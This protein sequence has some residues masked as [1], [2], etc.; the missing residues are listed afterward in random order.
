MGMGISQD[1]FEFKPRQ[2]AGPRQP[3]GSRHRGRTGQRR[4]GNLFRRAR[5]STPTNPNIHI[6]QNPSRRYA[7][8]YGPYGYQISP[9]A[10]QS[11]LY[12]GFMPTPYNNYAIPPYISPQRQMMMSP[13]QFQPLMM[14]QNIPPYQPG[15]IPQPNPMMMPQQ[16]PPMFPPY[17]P[18][19]YP[20]SV[21]PYMQ[22]SPQMQ[23]YYNNA[24]AF[25]PVSSP[26]MQPRPQT[27][28]ILNNIGVVAPVSTPYFQPQAPSVAV[29]TNIPNP[30]PT[31]PSRVITDWTRGG[32]ISPGFLGPPI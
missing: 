2:P 12:P 14:P 13:Q 9:F 3:T 19:P 10:Q 26:Y 30:M 31:G 17:G 32:V 1:Y 24:R 22:Q 8:G 23:P 29:P 27:V 15:M 21:P 20:M 6:R 28:P 5:S 7:Y 16:V 4:I 18:S 25:G 11:P